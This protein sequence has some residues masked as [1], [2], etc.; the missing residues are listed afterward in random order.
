MRYSK[1]YFPINA[2][3]FV[4]QLFDVEGYM[5]S[6]MAP[7]KEEVIEMVRNKKWIGTAC[8]LP[9]QGKWFGCIPDVSCPLLEGKQ[10]D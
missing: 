5:T 1:D 7:S 4:I 9:F 8:S 2:D 6:I 10:D 3:F